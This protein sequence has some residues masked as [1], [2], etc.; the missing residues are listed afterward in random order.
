MTIA[1]GTVSG[2]WVWN[3]TR[4]SCAQ[5][6]GTPPI[7]PTLPGPGPWCPPPADVVLEAPTDGQ[8]Y[9]RQNAGWTAI[10]GAPAININ[11]LT[12]GIPLVGD[13]NTDNYAAFHNIPNN[14]YNLN[15]EWPVAVTLSS[16]TG[17]VC[18]V[19]WPSTHNLKPNQAFFFTV[20]AGGSLPTGITPNTP[21]FITFANLTA[22]T[23]TF[24]TVNN[25]ML[26]GT[27]SGVPGVEGTP[28]PFGTST[29]SGVS[30]VLTGKEWI[31]IFVPPGC[32]ATHLPFGSASNRTAAYL[33]PAGI[34]KVRMMM[35]GAIFDDLTVPSPSSYGSSMGVPLPGP[36]LPGWTTGWYDFFTNASGPI[37]S[38]TSITINTYANAGTY[39]YPGQWVALI[40]LDLMDDAGKLTSGPPLNAYVEF[41]QITA[42]NSS[43]GVLNFKYPIKQTY[44]SSFPNL[45]NGAPGVNSIGGGRAMVIPMASAWDVE[46][47]VI[48]G[49]F[50]IAQPA[51][52][53]RSIT[54]IDC[55]IDQI[56][57]TGVAKEVFLK[58]CYVNAS[59]IDKMME[60]LEFND[61]TGSL[62]YSNGPVGLVSSIKGFRGS[63][64]N[65]PRNLQVNDSI[66]EAMTVGPIAFGTTDSVVI[67]NSRVTNFNWSAGNNAPGAGP[68]VGPNTYGMMQLSSWTL[69]NGTLTRDL[70]TVPQ[71]MSYQPWA[72]PGGKYFLRDVA[73]QYHNMGVPFTVL[74]VYMTGTAIINPSV[75]SIGS[76]GTPGPVTMTVVGGTGTAATISGTV[77]AQGDLYGS[78][79][80]V[81]SGG[82]YTVFP[83]SPAAVTGT[84]VPTGATVNFVAGGL[85][86]V[87]TTLR[88]IP[89]SQVITAGITAVNGTATTFTG[90][91]LANGTPV[92]L[93][94]PGGTTGTAVLPTGFSQFQNYWVVN[95]SANTFQ[96][97]ATYNGAAIVGT[98]TP[99]GTY[100]VVTGALS[101]QTHPCPRFTCLGN[102]GINTLTDMNGAVDEPMFSRFTR[103][104]SGFQ[105]T[106]EINFQAPYPEIWGNLVSLTVNV[107]QA[108]AG[109]AA[110]A[111]KVT[112]TC[113]TFVQPTIASPTLTLATMTEVIDLT[114]TGI[115]TI[116]ATAVTGSTGA[117]VLAAVPN[118]LTVGQATNPNS[119]VNFFQILCSG[120]PAKANGLMNQPIFTVECRTDQGLTRFA[121]NYAGDYLSSAATG[122][123]SNVLVD[124]SIVQYWP[125]TP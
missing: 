42:V 53:G 110:G 43:T 123:T 51:F 7:P 58:N 38:I 72:V 97:A 79:L 49:H 23:F 44:L 52:V 63:I 98:G 9:G 33:F 45:W 39:Y 117:D 77:R 2:R 92:I 113:P 80:A 25:T 119:T 94:I 46:Y 61:C 91:T 32:Y 48:G 30:V 101:I 114:V 124:T 106:T 18:V 95:T 115:R 10:S 102:T 27:P 20:T 73:N 125:A 105:N 82:N 89:A 71:N 68:N 50:P 13:G 120:L 108:A 29:P 111:A 12:G 16:G 4:W 28:I 15:Q 99:S 93:Q 64:S 31:N 107:V 109:V 116:T 121:S 21:Y 104:F 67:R 81:V 103:M 66:L 122:G 85:F 56:L 35:Y 24:S 60:Y 14:M 87:D 19:T 112:I 54:F 41:N 88:S 40:A 8:I 47:Q 69:T 78:T 34:S 5:P 22:T 118:W 83:T 59:Q 65:T 70:S 74:N 6:P 55:S 26:N 96:L 100:N 17:G 36:A 62:N 86:H 84:G 90:A 57:P 75:G 11:T 1:V 3:G 37:T 76:G